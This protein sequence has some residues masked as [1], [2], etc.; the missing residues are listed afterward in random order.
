MYTFEKSSLR[1][2][3]PGK[4]STEPPTFGLK[5]KYNNVG[6]TTCKKMSYLTFDKC[7]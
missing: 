5:Y 1:S 4:Y 7:Q 2:H 3:V 6:P